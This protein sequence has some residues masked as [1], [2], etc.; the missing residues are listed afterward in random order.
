[1]TGQFNLC[2]S[3]TCPDPP[4]KAGGNGRLVGETNGSGIGRGRAIP[5]R[6]K[7]NFVFVVAQFIGRFEKAR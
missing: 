2:S 6:G 4:P 3:R 7:K 5:T 1:M